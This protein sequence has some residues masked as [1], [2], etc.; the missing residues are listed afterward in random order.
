VGR[1]PGSGGRSFGGE[2]GVV[3]HEALEVLGVL[4]GVDG[5]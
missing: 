3:S 5:N 1:R 2:V 4:L